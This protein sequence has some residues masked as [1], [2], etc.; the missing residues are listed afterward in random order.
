MVIFRQ[1]ISATLLCQ[2]QELVRIISVL[3]FD[4][5]LL[6]VASNDCC[7][8]F[9]IGQHQASTSFVVEYRHSYVPRQTKLR[10]S[11]MIHHHRQKNYPFSLSIYNYVSRV[12]EIRGSQIQSN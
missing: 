11:N 12:C 5:T 4:S 9:P 6:E 10:F 8:W 2:E 3:V 7:F 1:R